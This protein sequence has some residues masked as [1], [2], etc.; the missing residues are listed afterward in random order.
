MVGSLLKMNQKGWER[1]R[2]WPNTIIL[3]QDKWSVCRE[4]N[5]GP[6]D[7]GVGVLPSGRRPSVTVV[8]QT[9]LVWNPRRSY[10][11]AASYCMSELYS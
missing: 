8:R 3:D 9:A 11:I 5:P 1:N 10:V 6:L 2:S 7:Y 4:L